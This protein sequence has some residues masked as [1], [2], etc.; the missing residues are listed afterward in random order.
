MG[1]LF[2]FD[3]SMGDKPTCEDLWCMKDSWVTVSET[4]GMIMFILNVIDP[5]LGT[6][7]GSCC[8]KEGCH[9]PAFWCGYAQALTMSCCVG[10]FWAMHW[11]FKVWKGNVGNT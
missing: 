10:W 8:N 7:I 11:G 4:M 9:C 6:Y 1:N 2:L 3:K 5:P